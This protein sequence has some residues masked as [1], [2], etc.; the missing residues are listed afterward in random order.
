MLRSFFS[1]LRLCILLIFCATTATAQQPANDTGD[2]IRIHILSGD[3]IIHSKTDSGDYNMFIGNVALRQ[4]TDTLYCDSLYRNETKRKLEAFGNVRIMQQGG[5][6]ATG[7]YLR[8]QEE[9]KMAFMKGNVHLTDGKNDL[10]CDQLFYNLDTK[11]A[12]YDNWGQL[13][14]DST[15]VTSRRG[16]YNVNNKEARFIGDAIITDPSYKITSQDLMYNTEKKI[17]TFYAKSTVISDSGRSV[18]QTSSGYYDATNVIAH[19]EGPSSIWNDGQ[20]IEADT[21]RYNK[22]TGFGF[23]IGHV[24]STDTA[25]H[26]TIYCGYMEF[27]RRKRTLWATIKPVMVQVNGK[28]TLYIRAD[29]FYGAPMERIL[30]KRK[31]TAEELKKDTIAG[32]AADTLAALQR[33]HRMP[34]ADTTTN[35]V[36]AADSLKEAQYFER[37][38]KED[39]TWI[40]PSYKYRMPDFKSDTA[41]SIADLYKKSKKGKKSN[42]DLAG[43][44][45]IPDTTYADSTAPVYFIGYNHVKIFS[46]SLQGRCDSVCYTRNDST[47]RMIVAPIVWSHNSQI[48]GDTIL[49]RMD[50][51]ELR[52][53]YVPNNAF[54]VSQTGPA[55]AELFDQVQGRTLT[56]YFVNNEIT[57]M[58][59]F[60][61]AETIYYPKDES[62]AYIGVD[63]SKSVRMRVYFKNQE[64]LKIKQEQDVETKMIPLDQADLPNMRL[65]KFKWLIDERPRTKEELFE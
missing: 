19:F 3:V 4:G 23:A 42:S 21:M 41:M 34:K 18:L 61:N 65:S 30:L 35:V 44:I 48:T 22:T 45:V 8:Y 12:T 17:T 32:A 59:V 31:P 5:T 36:Y 9:T 14:N 49:L 33:Q 47:I 38:L 13:H 7:D 50:S 51:S 16:V 39:T 62:G 57:H 58:N 60:P 27:L 56:A 46:D 43:P 54:V 26:S 29:T 63:Q 25:R 24:I 2:K 64:I 40:V 1:Y 11:T 20:Y 15:T 55:K 37:V 52:S 28:D 53:M 6:Q 10:E